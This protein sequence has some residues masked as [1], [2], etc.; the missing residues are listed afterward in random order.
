MQNPEELHRGH[1][2]RRAWLAVVPSFLAACLLEVLVFAIIDP[3]QTHW[4]GQHGQPSAQT[5][6][7]LG[8][9]VF[10]AVTAACSVLVLWLEG[11]N[12]PAQPWVDGA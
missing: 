9:F 11:F 6:Y 8:F 4:P 10:W 3:S 5:V 1:F 7:T 12:P 2:L